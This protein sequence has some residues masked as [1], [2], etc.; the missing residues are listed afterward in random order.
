MKDDEI[1]SII[2]AK[3]RRVKEEV[4]NL[5]P[6]ICRKLRAARREQKLSQIELANEIGCKQSALSMFEQ[7]DGTKLNDDAVTKLAKKFGID[8]FEK[9]EPELPKEPQRVFIPSAGVPARG[10]CP[11]PSCPSNEIYEVDGKTCYK[12]N[13]QAADPIGAKF[14]AMCGEVLIKKC[15]N[16]GADVHEGGFCSNCAEPYIAV[17]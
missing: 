3:H 6:E 14:C 4:I 7:G 1:K 11:N 13:R 8:I 10:F 9:P 15:T 12:P 2:H 17:I 5:K 16:C